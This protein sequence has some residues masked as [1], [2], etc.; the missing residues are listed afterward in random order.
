MRYKVTY[1]I[2]I[3]K[4]SFTHNSIIFLYHILSF[5]F[6]F[7]TIISLLHFL[8][9]VKRKSLNHFVHFDIHMFLIA[10]FYWIRAI[11]LSRHGTKGIS[12]TMSLGE[13]DLKQF[14]SYNKLSF[15]NYWKSGTTYLIFSSLLLTTTFTVWFNNHNLFTFL[16]IFLALLSTRSFHYFTFVSQNYNAL[17][18][19]VT[20]L[21]VFS[22]YNNEAVLAT[23]SILLT[24]VLSFTASV[25]LILI[26]IPL[27]LE[28]GNYYLMLVLIPALFSLIFQISIRIGTSSLKRHFTTVL[29]SIGAFASVKT[30]YTRTKH[31]IIN[32]IP[33]ICLLLSF[34]FIL[35]YH[36]GLIPYTTF[37][38]ILIIFTNFKLLRF[39][40][41]QSID[42][43][44]LLY[45]TSVLFIYGIN[46]IFLV[47]NFFLLNYF[48]YFQ[49]S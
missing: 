12:K 9:N 37:S 10:P 47:I 18:W 35:F 34:S 30:K 25:I 31:S 43:L 32:Y 11:N 16:L 49:I 22:V 4:D 1:F 3:H 40:D 48:L 5:Y 23:I 27:S 15:F 21:F 26:S 36:H 7:S 46:D 17:G 44:I 2:S 14:W 8:A 39:I 41:N 6:L 38:I 20:P 19:A 45:S 33:R 13:C 42:I 29:K 24:T 28:S